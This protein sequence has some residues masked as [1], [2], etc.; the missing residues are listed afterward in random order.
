MSA[1]ADGFADRFAGGL[2]DVSVGGFVGICERFRRK[3]REVSKGCKA[4]EAR[5]RHQMQRSP[6]KG[7]GDP[8]FLFITFLSVAEFVRHFNSKT[9]F[10][11]V[12]NV[13]K[14]IANVRVRLKFGF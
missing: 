8:S 2:A 13:R 10:S 11:S 1:P 14:R 3:A 4:R 9:E 7:F 5:P 6:K 12:P